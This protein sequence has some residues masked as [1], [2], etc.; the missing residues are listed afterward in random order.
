[1]T[2]TSDMGFDTFNVLAE[3]NRGIRLAILSLESL[4]RRE[5]FDSEQIEILALSIL[6]AKAT[7]N[8]YLISV[9]G[10]SEGQPGC[11]VRHCAQIVGK[12]NS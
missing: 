9:L 3:F 8:C 4:T 2:V 10:A 6:H 12:H 11:H 7:T 1:M 5:E